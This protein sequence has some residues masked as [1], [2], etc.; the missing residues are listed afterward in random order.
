MQ[1]GKKIY[2]ASDFH[3]GAPNDTKSPERERLICK[4]LDEIRHDAEEIFLAGDIFDFWYEYTYTIPKGFVRML[5]KVAELQD[6]GIKIH[7]FSGNH[8]TWM[9]DYF[10]KEIG[11][12]VNHEPVTRTFNGKNFYIGHGDGL[13]PGDK[14]YKLL[15]AVFR[16]KIAQWLYSRI[17]PN[18]AFWIA[19]ASS[20]KSRAVTGNS[21]EIFE[22]SEKEWLFLFCRDYIQSH[23]VDYFVFGHRHLPLDL[24]VDGKARYVNLGDWLRYNSY[25][26]FDG[27]KLEL[28]YYGK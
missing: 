28:K 11:V 23:K 27:S 21:D 18:L 7:F 25:A 2:F 14:F 22:G 12:S 6:S 10:Q 19:R 8:D 13:G 26:V 3:L 5:G 20:L 1:S 24:D 15:K 4:W 9:K 17:H 16:S